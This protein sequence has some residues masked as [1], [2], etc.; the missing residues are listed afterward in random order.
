MIK[1]TLTSCG[2]SSF[3]DELSESL[4]STNFFFSFFFFLLFTSEST[5][6]L[7]FFSDITT[8]WNKNNIKKVATFICL[9]DQANW[10]IGNRRNYHWPMKNPRNIYQLFCSSF[11]LED[12]SFLFFFFRFFRGS[13]VSSSVWLR[14]F[15]C[16]TSSH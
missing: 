4:D 12:F 5:R 1:R 11:S 16:C 6:L 9:N 2:E 10:P 3:S 15:A 8:I 7:R 13:S 14:F